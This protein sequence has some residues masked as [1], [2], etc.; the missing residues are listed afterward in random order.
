VKR[1]KRIAV[2]V[3]ALA[4]LMM[5]FAI[6]SRL[7]AKASTTNLLSSTDIL[8]FPVN[9][10]TE[11]TLA[12]A[13]SAGQ[14]I[15]TYRLYRHIAY[16]AYPV[17]VDYESLDVGVPVKIDGQDIDATNAPILLV[18]NNP[19]YTASSN[20]ATGTSKLNSD[21]NAKL[22]LAAGYV[23][24]VPGLRGWNLLSNG[25]YYGKAPAAIVDLKAVVRYIRYNKGVMPGNTEWIIASGISGGGALSALLG[26]SG[27]SH[28]YDAALEQIGAANA[29]DNIYAS[30]PYCPITDLEHAD[31]AYEWEFGTNPVS[32]SLVNQSVSQQLKNAFSIYQASL[33]LQGKNGYGTITADNYGDYLV[34]TY[35]IPSANKYLNALTNESRV[36]YLSQKSWITWS[37]NSALF[38]F[39]DYVAYIGRSKKLPAFDAFDLTAWENSLFGNSTTNARHF[40]NFS[41]QYAS[42]DPNAKI[43]SELQTLV[44]MM[45]PMYFKQQNNSDCAQYWFIRTGTKDTDTAHIIFGNLATSLENRG[46]TVNASLY[47]DG[48]HGVNQDPEAFV[49][50]VRQITNYSIVART[51]LAASAFSSVTVLRGWTWWF[52]VHSSG[53]VAP[54]T[55]QWYENTSLLTGQTAMVL[56][57]TKTATGTYTFYCKVTDAQGIAVNSNN[58]ILTVIG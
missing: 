21:T 45:N 4:L 6:Q 54:Y 27:N 34:K 33:K 17:D 46:K 36:T 11:Q 53:G 52:F 18:V 58:V 29:S 56:P 37:N 49:A 23:V 12:V 41:L 44:N 39:A 32:G 55:Y 30:A 42:G 19:G 51:L 22:A 26:V 5:L 24:V 57:V 10:Y 14:R 8:R 3:L 9:N 13:T 50:W 31:M 7:D 20:T 47:W 43:D 40:T 48:T 1:V 28:L 16:V 2:A 35:L 25:T 15:V 38:T